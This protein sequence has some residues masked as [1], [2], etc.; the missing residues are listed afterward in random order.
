VRNRTT[1]ALLAFF[2]GGIGGH[3]FYL[4]RSVQGLLYLVFC[5]TFIPA[6]IAFIEAIILLTMSDADFNVKYNGGMMLVAAATPQN[7]VVNVANTAHAG[8]DDLTGKLKSL[9][10]LRIAGAL[11]EEEFQTQKQRVLSAGK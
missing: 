6:V 2:L 1:A 5:W 10:D 7:I 8:T 11:T 4:G 9:N 3:K